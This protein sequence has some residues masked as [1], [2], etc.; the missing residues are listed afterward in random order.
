MLTSVRRIAAVVAV[1]MTGACAASTTFSA[2]A[3]AAPAPIAKS[4][5]GMHFLGY[6]SRAYPGMSFSSARIWGMGVSWKDLQPTQPTPVLDPP[7]K[8]DP[9]AL[10][11]LDSY[12][13]GFRA[14][15]VDPVIVL[16]WTPAWAADGCSHVHNGTDYGVQTCA[17]ADTS[18]T[19]PW[20]TYVKSLATRYDGHHGHPKVT[21]F[22]TW[23][24]GNLP[25]GWTDSIAK[26]A[27][28][29]ASA[30]S[31][32]HGLG[33]GQ[34]L[35]SPSFAVTY[36]YVSTPLSWLSD[37]QGHGFLQQPGG[38]KFDVFNVHL[39]PT[40]KYAKAGYGPE[41]SIRQFAQIKTILSQRGVS[42]PVWDTEVNS[43]SVQSGTTFG[44]GMAGA[45]QVDR[46]LVLATENHIARTFWYAADD[47]T[48]GGVWMENSDLK[49]LSYAG[50]G[51][52][53]LA[54]NLTGARP[55]GCSVKTVGTN[56]WNYTCKYHL[57]SG[58]NMLALW[59]TGSSFHYHGP[60]G[61]RNWY[62]AAGHTHRASKSTRLTVSHTPI[63]VSGTFKI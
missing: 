11:K 8:M 21:Y 6:G 20:A 44:G 37:N 27:L 16:G 50:L 26:L 48:W 61:T 55:Y 1:L 13:D 41:W 4:A 14:H 19:G 42:T 3:L 39:Y 47:R 9:T 29:Q 18:A 54:R 62:D 28:V 57:A 30:Y 63:F 52:R 22:E 40:F 12:V 35:L 46:T 15:G 23:N 5:F 36:G 31:V 25:F 2:E 17:P 58:R 45:A 32:I 43:G 51:Y 33:Q 34:R 38:R 24:E 56:K 49:S 53:F 59:T 7:D 60:S 10:A